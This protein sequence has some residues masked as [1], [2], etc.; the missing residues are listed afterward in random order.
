MWLKPQC[1]FTIFFRR[2][3]PT[4]KTA[5]MAKMA[6][7]AAFTYH[8]RIITVAKRDPGSTSS[9]LGLV[10]QIEMNHIFI[11]DIFIKIKRGGWIPT[12][13]ISSK[14]KFFNL[15]KAAV[16]LLWALAA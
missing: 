11:L 14:R 1:C 12:L 10:K 9:I 4:A 6:D 16:T 13:Y 5:K 8:A 3:K 15:Y 2:L 7:L